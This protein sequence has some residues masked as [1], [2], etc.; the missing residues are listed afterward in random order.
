[1]ERSEETIFAE[2]PEALVEEMLF[3]SETVGDTLYESF[4]EIQQNKEIMRRQLREKNILRQDTDFGYPQLPTTCGVDGSYAVERLLAT[5]I[6]TCAAVA[7]EGLIPPSEKRHWVKPNHRVFIQPERHDPDTGML[8]RGLMILME[9]DLAVN[10]PHDIVF[11]DGSF[12]TPIIY[13]NQTINKILEMENNGINISLCKNIKERFKK[14]SDDYKVIL[15]SS[16]SDKLWVSMPKYTTRR[17]LGKMFNWPPQ[18]DDRALLTTILCPGEFTTPIRIESP[19]QPWHFR[20]PSPEK[21]LERIKNEIISAIDNLYIIYY[22]PHRWTPAFRIEIASSIASNNSR[23]AVLLQGIKYQAGTPG[24]ME[25]Y[26]LYIADRMVKHLG[27]AIPV[28]RQIATKKMVD[29]H[30]GD[31]SDLFFSMHGYRTESER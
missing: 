19:Q 29:L 6:V 1:M 3:N 4:E 30:Q 25:V 20:A 8:V 27:R 7:V 17:E 31:I 16:R 28:F 12:T 5:D 13:M 14:F 21:G 9:L 24:I 22:R 2:L 10:A 23:I 18:F 11:L 26:P 15:E